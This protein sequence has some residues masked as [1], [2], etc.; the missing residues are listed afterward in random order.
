MKNNIL[1]LAIILIF[2]NCK[3]Q[4]PIIDTY[5]PQGYPDVNGAYYKD[6]NGFQNQYVGTWLYTNGTNSLKIT[7]QKR[8]FKYIQSNINYYDDFL[9]GE[10]QYIENG[11]EKVNTLNNLN[12]DY[13]NDIYKYNLY[14]VSKIKYA[15]NDCPECGVNEHRLSMNFNEPSR[16]NIEDLYNEFRI[17]A[18]S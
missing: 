11:I 9:D 3:A 2:I 8:D 16:Y 10:Y 5:G 7:F 13:G 6:V 1:K 15:R 4:T 17:R 18:F 12:I 14:S